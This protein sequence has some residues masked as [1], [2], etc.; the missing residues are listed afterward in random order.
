M[1]VAATLEARL[2]ALAPIVLEITDDSAKHAGHAGAAAGG[3][4]FSVTIVSEHFLGLSRLARQRAVLDRVGDLIPHPVHALAI[5]ALAPDE[6]HSS[7]K[8]A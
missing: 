7:R 3:G 2:G 1:N 4:H 5:R 6:F 8:D